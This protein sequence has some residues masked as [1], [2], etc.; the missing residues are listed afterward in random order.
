M[1]SRFGTIRLRKTLIGG[2]VP[3]ILLWGALVGCERRE[4]G[5]KR[6]P[7]PVVARVNGKQLLQRDFEMYL[8]HDYD[9][10]L[11]VQEKRAYLDR[12]ITTELLYEYAVQN[13]L[14]VSEDVA[15][16]LEQYKKDLVADRLVQ[17]VINEQAVVTETECRAYY[18]SRKDEYTLELRVSHILVAN[19]EDVEK[20]REMLQKRTFS[21]V[22]RRHSLDK[23]TGV[24]GDLGYL[25][26]GNMIPQ[27]EAV[28]FK[29]KVGEVS[30]P[31]ESEFGYHFVKLTDVRETRNKLEYEDVAEEISGILLL[32]KR[33]TVYNNLTAQLMASAEIDVI[34]LGLRHALQ[35]DSLW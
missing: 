32:E 21:W 14:G 5:S 1:K 26:K 23:H 31:I 24:G 3:P 16:R 20:V 9:R 19:G 17:K 4:V 22:A 27:F 25:S 8:P 7:S 28:V 13:D 15:A 33:A 30:E 35:A 18:E 12:W 34:D 2:L 10:V 11:T 6:E 29:M